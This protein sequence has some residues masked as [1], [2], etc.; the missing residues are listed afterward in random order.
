MV[1]LVNNNIMKQF[2]NTLLLIPFLILSCA[3]AQHIE[4]Y[5]P[6]N[7]FLKT[8]NLEKNT[9]I[10]QSDKAANKQALRIFN[11][12]EGPNHVMDSKNPIDY[13]DGLFVE[14]HWKK[15]YEQYAQDTIKKYWQKE[16]F[17][18]YGFLLE[19]GTGLTLKYDIAT[20]YMN[21]RIENVIIISEPM[22]YMDK[23]YIM[24]YFNIASFAG[25][26]QSKLVIMTKPKEKWVIVRVMGDYVFN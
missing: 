12:G 19:K 17:P 2:K 26:S 9:Y 4:N 16:D 6:I 10:L 15:M 8:Q 24:F 11:S 25:S 5:E 20:K 18:E 21:T 3:S 1:L 22:Y 23:K 14:K 13:T 7:V